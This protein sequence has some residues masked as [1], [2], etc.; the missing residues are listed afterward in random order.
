MPLKTHE[1]RDMKAALD[2]DTLPEIKY[3]LN[4][5]SKGKLV[6]HIKGELCLVVA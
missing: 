5:V 6:M 2:P 3:I 4:L 1:F